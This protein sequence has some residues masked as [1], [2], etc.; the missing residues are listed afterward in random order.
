[1]D[2][3][4]IVAGWDREGQKK[5]EEME[6]NLKSPR[7]EAVCIDM[8]NVH[9][10]YNYASISILCIELKNDVIWTYENHDHTR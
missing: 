3:Q 7:I 8:L 1:M 9:H 6:K 2:F 4:R 10:D 5:G